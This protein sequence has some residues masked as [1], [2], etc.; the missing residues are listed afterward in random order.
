VPTS[1]VCVGSVSTWVGV[2]CLSGDVIQISVRGF[3]LHGT[4]PNAIGLLTTLTSLDISDNVLGGQ[5]PSSLGGL[6]ALKKLDA[7]E[8]AFTGT[9]PS[10]LG[11]L[12]GLVS[13]NLG[14]NRFTGSVPASLSALSGLTFLDLNVPTLDTESISESGLCKSSGVTCIFYSV[15]KRSGW[16][17]RLGLNTICQMG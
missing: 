14:E 9:V 6:S 8:N 17:G 10:A 2:T 12:R 16:N 4:L 15:G 13:L 11:D 1:R 3:G 7:S 5:L